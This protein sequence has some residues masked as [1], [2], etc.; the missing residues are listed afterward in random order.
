MECNISIENNIERRRPPTLLFSLF[1]LI[2]SITSSIVVIAYNLNNEL[3]I[4][5]TITA[6]IIA[7]S[8]FI[9]I[10][11][12]V[13]A[14]V[15]VI[16]TASWVS[17]DL[18]GNWNYAGA[19]FLMAGLCGFFSRQL[20]CRQDSSNMRMIVPFFFIGIIALVSAVPSILRYFTFEALPGVGYINQSVNVLG[21]SSDDVLKNI[22]VQTMTYVAWGGL[23]WAGISLSKD[24]AFKADLGKVLLPI[25]AA[26][27]I[28]AFLQLTIFPQVFS[29]LSW[30]RADQ[31]TGLLVDANALG[32]TS[33][34]ILA[35]SP[36]WFPKKWYFS[37]RVL[38]TVSF[39]FLCLVFA[40]SRSAFF[41]VAAFTLLVIVFYIMYC[42]INKKSR[43]LMR[44]AIVLVVAALS[45]IVLWSVISQDP[46]LQ[47]L[48]LVRR[49]DTTMEML[50]SG[51]KLNEIVNER[52]TM[53]GLAA[54]MALSNPA[55]GF[56]PGTFFCEVGN[57]SQQAGISFRVIDNAMNL[58]LHVLAEL[59][60]FA[61]L[62]L[63]V[64]FAMLLLGQWKRAARSET[65]AKVREYSKLA[66]ILA[67][68]LA[69][70]FGPHL[71][72][73]CPMVVT[74]IFLGMMAGDFSEDVERERLGG[75]GGWR[76]GL[77]IGVAMTVVVA[78]SW[79]T[80]IRIHPS[81][82][83]RELRWDINAGFYE[84]EPLLEPGDQ[85]KQ[86]KMKFQWCDA[87]AV[88]TVK[89]SSR[90]LHVR[91][92]TGH[93]LEGGVGRSTDVFLNGEKTGFALFPD[94]EWK[95]SLFWIEEKSDQR[96]K[97]VLLTDPPYIPD[98]V[99]GNGDKRNLG[100]AIAQMEFID[101][102]ESESYGFWPEESDGRIFQWTKDEAYKRVVLG[103]RAIS[104]SVRAD[105]IEISKS[106]VTVHIDINGLLVQEL[107]LRDH[108]WH[109]MVIEPS[110]WRNDWVE[111][112]T[113]DQEIN[114]FLH[115]LVDRTW[116][117]AKVS[118][119]GDTRALGVAVSR[120]EYLNR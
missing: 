72:L 102:L 74:L 21:I 2:V 112:E 93:E 104:F 92:R 118:S 7:I 31:A 37:L 108:K 85:G 35:A 66:F 95:D 70:F 5:I 67:L 17:V 73:P 117:P 65:D 41:M 83:W 44:M 105:H 89:P 1:Y 40:G 90:I 42:I 96:E 94:E 63:I 69:F 57:F 86:S 52:L 110:A 64:I 82:Q 101:K 114:G 45:V 100:T 30:Q 76:R 111:E 38:A 22:T 62:S 53:W 77:L 12:G 6:A 97:L 46:N 8:Y 120:I 84:A 48:P 33:A 32:L 36:I 71:D 109:D 43:N 49:L 80:S 47:E 60:V 9:S 39:L 11:L 103:N 91:W 75:I 115:F 14:L 13:I 106:P 55:A 54:W 28:A 119:S 27:A 29:T 56:G 18:L 116:V 107:V 88:R 51:A 10:K 61:C 113:G 16:S 25:A 78:A 19:A 26:N 59:G 68:M 81:N 3:L 58:Y 99:E 23:F 50:F 34:V 15:I 20:L 98:D 4:F 87:T 79:M 24:D